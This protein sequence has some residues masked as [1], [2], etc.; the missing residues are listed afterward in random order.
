MVTF[1]RNTSD[2]LDIFVSSSFPRWRKNYCMGKKVQKSQFT[3]TNFQ[4]SPIEWMNVFILPV[5]S[6]W[7]FQLFLIFYYSKVIKVYI[8]DVHFVSQRVYVFLRFIAFLVKIASSSYTPTI[9]VRHCPL[10]DMLDDYTMFFFN[11]KSS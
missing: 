4:H 6:G 10:E 8:L 11:P 2:I 3:R 1:F 5:P 9:W 7:A